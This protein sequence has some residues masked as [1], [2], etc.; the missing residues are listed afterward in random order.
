VAGR[1]LL[2]AALFALLSAPGAP[3]GPPARASIVGGQ[4][5]SIGS[6]PSIAFVL[7][8]WDANGDGRLES[9]AQ[10]TG[11]VVAPRWV[12]SAA[13]CG[14]QPNG[15]PVQAMVTVTGVADLKGAGE[16]IAADRL[17][18]PPGWTPGTLT[19][20]VLLI[21]LRAPSSRPPLPVATPGGDYMTVAGRPN[22]AGWG[23][24][25]EQATIFTDLLHE[26][27]LALQPDSVCEAVAGGFDAATQTCAGTLNSAGVC[28]G[29]SGGPLLVFERA[30]GAPVLWGLTSYGPQLGLGLPVCSL[31]APAVFARVSAFAAWISRTV[32]P[33]PP[34]V[35]EPLRDAAAPVL[36]HVRLG[37]SRIRA[38]RRTMLSFRLSEA[39]AVT[40][41]LLRK[42]G[43]RLKPIRRVPFGA[44]AGTVKRGFAAR[45]RSKA[46]KRGGYAL[47]LTAVDTAGN[48][49]K[50]ASVAF[51]VVR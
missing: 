34:V 30:T 29:D 47:R 16:A 26:A 7:A 48:R 24:T 46:L 4:S 13:H 20:D 40:V 42:R 17:A 3:A 9:F 19:R 38:G 39:A 43:T 11:T 22:A 33:A 41:T 12:I 28:T 37:T 8:A 2:L 51:R 45:L 21:H 6:W 36:S 27:Y 1:A 18:V 44:P 10:C 23:T 49:S 15:D 35:V 14:S 25:D 31:R 50:P 5:A 32:T